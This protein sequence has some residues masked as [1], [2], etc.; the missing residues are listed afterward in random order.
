M[1]QVSYFFSSNSGTKFGLL[2]NFKHQYTIAKTLSEFLNQ[3]TVAKVH[4]LKLAV[5]VKGGT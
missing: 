2:A 1:P 4:S 3:K 5:S